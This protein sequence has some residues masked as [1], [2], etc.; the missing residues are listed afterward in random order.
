MLTCVGLYSTAAQYPCCAV[1]HHV[2]SRGS[3][4]LYM[5]HH[6]LDNNSHMPTHVS[7][8]Q[9]LCVAIDHIT[10]LTC[11]CTQDP[12]P[13]LTG[14]ILPSLQALAEAALSFHSVCLAQPALAAPSTQQADPSPSAGLQ[15][16][17]STSSN[18][19]HASQASTVP[20][21]YR[22]PIAQVSTGLLQSLKHAH[23]ACMHVL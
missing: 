14:E 4:F 11:R 2:F 6:R 18:T 20:S 23:K 16:A 7:D 22:C 8:K 1:V 13:S 17:A 21:L 12:V 19:S 15:R 3:K 9:G 5:L 10:S